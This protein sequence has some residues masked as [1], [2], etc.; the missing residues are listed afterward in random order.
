[1]KSIFDLPQ[2][3]GALLEE[4]MRTYTITLIGGNQTK[5]IE[6]DTNRARR[7]DDLLNGQGLAEHRLCS[8]KL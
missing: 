6:D 2:Q 8:P 4:C 1:M 5:V 7:S 3:R